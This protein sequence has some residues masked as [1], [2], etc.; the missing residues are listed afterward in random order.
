[1]NIRHI[2]DLWR[3]INFMLHLRDGLLAGFD[4]RLAFLFAFLLL[5]ELFPQILSLFILGGCKS[6]A[7]KIS[8]VKTD[9]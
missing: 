1:M 5:D 6:V 8:L 3:I 4:P 7:K 2:L 9:K